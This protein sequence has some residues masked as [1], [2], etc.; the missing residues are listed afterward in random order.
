MMIPI[1]LNYQEGE[2]REGKSSVSSSVIGLIE[3]TVLNTEKVPIMCIPGL[4]T[5][6][7]RNLCELCCYVAPRTKTTVLHLSVYFLCCV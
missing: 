1:T 2:V 6:L 4:I 5:N 7:D 3:G